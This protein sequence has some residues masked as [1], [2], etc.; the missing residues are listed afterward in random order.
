MIDHNTSYEINAR[1]FRMM[2][3]YVAPGKDSI[4][5]TQDE[6][7]GAWNEWLRSNKEILYSIFTA[8]DDYT[9]LNDGPDK[10]PCHAELGLDKPK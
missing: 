2:T 9:V 3:G 8:L 4:G 10:E 7:W 5:S 1:A 6:R